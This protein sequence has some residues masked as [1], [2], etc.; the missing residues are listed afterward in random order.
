MATKDLHETPFSEETITKLE[1]FESYTKEWLPTFIMSDYKEIWIFDFFAGTGYDKNGIPGSSIR[2][3]QQI[4]DQIENILKKQTQ[5]NICLNEY[6]KNKF[7][8]LEKACSEFIANKLTVEKAKIKIH[9]YQKDFAILFP[10]LIDKIRQYPSLVF[11]DQN[12]IKFLSEEYFLQLAQTKTTDFLYFLS[13]SYFIR[14]G[15][16]PEFQTSFRLDLDKALKNPYKYIH[17]SILE[18]I[19]ERIPTNLNLSL[20][21]FTLKKGTNIY[22]IIF[23]ASHPRAVNKF[24]ETAWKK[25]S[26]NGEANFDIDE[27]SLKGQLDLFDGKKLTK[28]EQFA[29]SLRS[30]LLLGKIK[31]NKEVFDYTQQQGHI[32]SHATDELKKM[33]KENLI[34]YDEKSPLITY[35]QIYKNHRIITFKR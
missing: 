8:L 11:I 33:K 24:L 25:N 6:D 9:Y 29:A 5:I 10:T 30:L 20:Y 15:K 3:L 16:T 23:G 26:I 32:A 13:S 28:I 12:G 7:Q 22:G 21:P 2:I 19:K 31:T 1:I 18:Q 17:K 35:D 27:D 4:T 14:F 34:H